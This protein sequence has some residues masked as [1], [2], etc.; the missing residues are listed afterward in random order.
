MAATCRQEGCGRP[1]ERAL[2]Y[3]PMHAPSPG[4]SNFRCRRD[5]YLDVA[6]LVMVVER[7]GR[8]VSWTLT[9]TQRRMY[10]RAKKAGKINLDVAERILENFGRGIPETYGG[11][12]GI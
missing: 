9:E 1:R 2:R 12:D 5:T 8:P 3:C 11:Y 10:Y 6:P 4:D 7:S